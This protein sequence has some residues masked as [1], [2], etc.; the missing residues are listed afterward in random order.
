ML[1]L[2]QV[3]GV[4]DNRCDLLPLL[5]LLQSELLLCRK[6][7]LPLQQFLLLLC[8]NFGLLGRF[9]HFGLRRGL[10]LGHAGNSRREIRYLEQVME[11][12][13]SF[14]TQYILG[15]EKNVT[16]TRPPLYYLPFAR[17]GWS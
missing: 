3:L 6:L 16:L 8:Q 7:L 2:L 17:R 14:K 5:L 10:W 1:G 9:L 15:L 4:E 12:S 13:F 11:R